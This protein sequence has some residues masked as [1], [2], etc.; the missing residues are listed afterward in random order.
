MARRDAAESF[1]DFVEPA[2]TMLLAGSHSVAD[3]GIG[4]ACTAPLL[5]API[6]REKKSATDE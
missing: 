3:Q 5:P 2:G 4:P 1:R 6:S